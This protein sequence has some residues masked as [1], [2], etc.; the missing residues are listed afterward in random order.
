MKRFVTILSI[1]SIAVLSVSAC[2]PVKEPD[3]VSFMVFGEPAELQAYQNLVSAFKKGHADIPIELIHIPSQGDYRKRLAADLTSGAPA[4]VVLVSY[5][6]FAEL[7]AKN[8]FEPLGPYLDQS[9]QINTNDF[10]PQAIQPY[11]WQGQLICIP[12]NISSLVMYYNKDLFDAAGASYPADNWSWDDFISTAQALTLDTDQDGQID[13]YGVGIEP[14]LIRVAPF[15]WQNNGFVSYQN[16]LALD[17]PTSVEAIQWFV[18]WQVKYHIVPNAVEEV[19]ENSESR[20]VNGRAA[21]YFNS[22]RLTPTFREITAFDWDVAPLPV[23]KTKAT[24]LHSDAYCLTSASAHKTEAW[25]FIEFANSV[26]G[27]TI[28]AQSGRTVPSLIEVAESDAFLD[29]SA[30]PEHSKV[31]LDEIPN[32][33]ALPQQVNW[34]EIEEIVS[35]EL[36]RA[37]YGN[38]STLKAMQSAVFRTRPLFTENE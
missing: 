38:V 2:S 36:Q 30:K 24:I 18:D 37:F 29:P 25:K 13:Q 16:A 8:A 7:A 10:Y 31:F 22:R 5:R 1:L 21:M 17:Y 11:M 14:E 12:Q 28:V 15:I 35:E 9:D 27:Q 34:A 4:D 33:V 3:P 20:F 32:I 6:R 23:G 26:E 19:S